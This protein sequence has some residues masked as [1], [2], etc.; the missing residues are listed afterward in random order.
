MGG[1][2]EPNA[3]T[4][5]RSVSNIYQRDIKHNLKENFFAYRNIA[6]IIA[7]KRGL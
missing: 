1:C 5:E 3:R 2:I 6:S 4:E 7:I